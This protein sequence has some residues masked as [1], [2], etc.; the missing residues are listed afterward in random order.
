MTD[1]SELG[2]F[3]LPD[4]PENVVE[5]TF[6][7]D[8]NGA[9][10]VTQGQLLVSGLWN[11]EPRTIHGVLATDHV[12]LVDALVTQSGTSFGRFLP[13]RN[14]ETWYCSGAFRGGQYDG[15]WPDNITSVEFQVQSLVWCN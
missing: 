12:K 7:V 10:L 6:I 8:D 11:R 5:G 4:D 3:W 2:R 1:V 15:D 14:Q 13:K 9:T